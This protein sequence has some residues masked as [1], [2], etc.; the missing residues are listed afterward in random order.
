MSFL[1]RLITPKTPPLTTLWNRIAATAREE[2]WYLRHA[3]P[4]T[5]DGRF[6]MVTLVMALVLLR[7]EREGRAQE[8]IWLTERFVDDMD[9][10]LREI[11]ISDQVMGKHVGNMVGALGGRLGAYR[12][13]LAAED[14]SPALAAALERNV[15]R[16]DD[17]YLSAPDL[18]EAAL[19][20]NARIE[21]APID[22]LLAGEF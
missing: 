20:L 8:N 10:S 2:H 17:K 12:D 9:G 19:V 1:K 15:Y 6:D 21:T 7:L 3:V 13:A 4:D 11:G 5:I 14:V 16:G 18:A 22:R